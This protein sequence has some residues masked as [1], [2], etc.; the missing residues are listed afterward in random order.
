LRKS[1]TVLSQTID[2]VEI[3]QAI[4][5]MLEK[6]LGRGFVLGFQMVQVI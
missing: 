4:N 5:S 2:P 3:A 6:A 1:Y